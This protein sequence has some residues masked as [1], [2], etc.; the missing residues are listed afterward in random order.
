M[1]LCLA[2]N[3]IV[4]VAMTIITA[5]AVVIYFLFFFV[6]CVGVCVHGIFCL[7]LDGV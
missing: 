3:T 2:S 1:V 7:Y 4:A 6:L 5:A